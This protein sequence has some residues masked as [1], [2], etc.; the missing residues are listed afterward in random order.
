MEVNPPPPAAPAADTP[1]GAAGV[2]GVVPGLT[3]TAAVDDCAVPFYNADMKMAIIYQKGN[4]IK[5]DSNP[6]LKFRCS[7]M[8]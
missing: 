2:A 8:A 7:L 5:T 3:V 6:G 1:E 4:E